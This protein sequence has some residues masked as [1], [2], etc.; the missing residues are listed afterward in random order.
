MKVKYY[1]NLSK[2]KPIQTNTNQTSTGVIDEFINSII[3]NRKPIADGYDGLRSIEL[4]E[5]LMEN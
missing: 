5:S 3:V 4:A 1:I 2:Y